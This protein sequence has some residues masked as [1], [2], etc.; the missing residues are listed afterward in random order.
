MRRLKKGSWVGGTHK[1][2][3]REEGTS[4][5]TNKKHAIE[6]YSRSGERIGRDKLG[7]RHERG[8]ENG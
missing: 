5:D 4:E 7:H 8:R 1:L 2:K 6:E 3:S